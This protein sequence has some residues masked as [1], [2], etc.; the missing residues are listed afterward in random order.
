[1]RD[2]RRKGA[3]LAARPDIPRDAQGRLDALTVS[4]SLS[5]DRL[6]EAGKRLF[7][8]LGRPPAGMA[9]EDI[10]I[11]LLGDDATE[12]M[13]QLRVSGLAEE[14]PGRLDL[15]PPVRGYA[16]RTAPIAAADATWFHH[17]LALARELAL[18]VGAD[19]GAEAIERLDPGVVEYRRRD[20]C[21]D[22]WP[23]LDPRSRR[24]TVCPRQF[25]S[26]ASARRGSGIAGRRLY[27]G[28]R[29]ARRGK[30]PRRSG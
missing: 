14:A 7:A 19:G 12:A 2:W 16:V 28:R 27:V 23:D 10:A 25:A 29:C 15:L 21:R 17:Y 1:M 24:D 13:R 9:E 26:A 3:E 8:L 22:R 11:G 18:R 5:T 20:R 6:D 4:L 30:L